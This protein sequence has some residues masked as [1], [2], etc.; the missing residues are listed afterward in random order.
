MTFGKGGYLDG[1]EALLKLLGLAKRRRTFTS[2]EE[3]AAYVMGYNDA[4]DSSAAVA[5]GTAATLSNQTAKVSLTSLAEA[6][7]SSAKLS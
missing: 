4:I 2:E 3:R 7:E 5:R 1:M 6:L